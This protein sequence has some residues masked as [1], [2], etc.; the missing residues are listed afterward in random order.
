MKIK[1]VYSREILDSR[2]NPTVEATVVLDNGLRESAIAPSGASTGKFEALELRDNQKERFKGKG[3]IK[4]CENINTTINRAITGMDIC[5]QNCID[6]KM[7]EADGTENK[8]NLGA[9]A[10]IAVSLAV[11]KTAALYLKQPLYRYLGGICCGAAPYSNKGAVDV[12]T[13][14]KIMPVPMMNILNGGVHADNNIDIQEFMIMP[15][16]AKTFKEAVR[17]CAEIYHCLKEILRN[18]S[19]S[20]S[21]GDEGGFAPLL[22]DDMEAFSL[23]VKAIESAGY[24]AGTQVKLALDAASSEWIKENKY[25]LPKKQKNY[26]SQEL[27]N[28]WKD[29]CEAFPL[30]SL[31]D[32]LGEEDENGWKVITTELGSNHLLV[33]DDLFVTNPERLKS[34]IKDGIANTILIKP[35][36]IGTLTETLETI[37]IAK[38]NGYGVI[39][40]HRSGE[41]EDTSISDIAVAVSAGYIKSGAP[42]RSERIA[43]YNRLLRIEDE[44]LSHNSF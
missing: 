11:A 43:K 25:T 13:L 1:G 28:Y 21:V 39:L 44:I 32:P 23:L 35:N 10:T 8:Q 42:A 33:G 9:N 26:T 15:V 20:T 34:G 16:G 36:Q 7:L 18:K 30:Y 17:W 29:I 2:G 4:A 38:K 12:V 3:V 31:E 41:S 27:I 37:N 6:N 19:Y 24:K 5:N 40:S 22:E 14:G